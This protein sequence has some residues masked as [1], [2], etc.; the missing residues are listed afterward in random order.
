MYSPTHYYVRVSRAETFTGRSLASQAG[1]LASQASALTSWVQLTVMTEGG[2]RPALP[3]TTMGTA[4]DQ[5]RP[6]G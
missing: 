4:G 1:A 2:P 3:L 6:R 5:G